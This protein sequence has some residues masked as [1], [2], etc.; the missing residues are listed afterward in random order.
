MGQALAARGVEFTAVYSSPALRCIQTA[1]RLLKGQSNP[2]KIRVEHALY[3]F[4]GAKDSVRFPVLW[5]TIPE[6][7]FLQF[8]PHFMDGEE[9]EANQI[10]VDRTYR[11]TV[12]E[13]DMAR[14]VGVETPEMFLKRSSEVCQS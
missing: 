10:P 1:Q 6:M 9:L 14:L 3:D 13:S 7:L 2:S 8:L 4:C 12:P 5:N 11:S